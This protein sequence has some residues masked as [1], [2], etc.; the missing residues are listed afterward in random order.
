MTQRDDIEAVKRAADAQSVRGKE[1]SNA[2]MELEHRKY[3]HHIYQKQS[4]TNYCKMCNQTEFA[5]IHDCSEAHI[6]VN[7]QASHYGPAEGCVWCERL[8]VLNEKH[9][10]VNTEYD[11]PS[12]PND[13]DAVNPPHYRRGPLLHIDIGEQITKGV[14]TITHSLQCIEV[15][16]RI[17]DPR[18]AVAFKYLWRVAFGGKR[19]PGETRPQSEID[20]RDIESAIWYLND[21]LTYPT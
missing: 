20:R 11:L 1:S 13:Y 12:E 19:E 9:P 6:S 4:G 14:K 3:G 21:W 5:T 8:K 2:T 10:G 15:M 7:R 16:R 17:Q 18:L